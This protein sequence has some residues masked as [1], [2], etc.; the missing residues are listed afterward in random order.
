MNKKYLTFMMI[1]HTE[2]SVQEFNVSRRFFW[3]IFCLVLLSLCALGYYGISYHVSFT[4]GTELSSIEGEN[5]ALQVELHQFRGKMLALRAEVEDLS[6]TDRMLRAWASFSRPGDGASRFPWEDHVPLQME[7][8]FSKTYKGLD[9]LLREAR[10]LTTSLDSVASAL[11]GREELHRHI[12]SIFPVLGEGWYSAPFGYRPDPFTGRLRL[13]NGIN[14]AGREGTEVVA[15][16]DGT[17][18]NVSWEK[19][20]G[21]YVKIDHQIGLQTVYGHLQSTPDLK[22][23]LFV[24]RGQVIG[25]LGKS[26]RTTA[27]NLHYMVIRNGHAVDPEKFI[28]SAHSTPPFSEIP[29]TP[30]P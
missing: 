26:G 13:N 28:F 1:P 15:T 16:A 30:S 23:G 22:S 10:F 27:P 14:I 12:P 7:E 8:A 11:Q 21:Y 25:K 3:G 20:L 18:E 19:N 4:P 6:E 17:V 24:K 29:V 5:S 2:G 9:H